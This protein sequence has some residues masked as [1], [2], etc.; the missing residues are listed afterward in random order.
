MVTPGG[1]GALFGL[2]IAP[3]GSGVYFV[4]DSVNTL[5]LLH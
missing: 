5:V 1:G 3:A 2:A 4:D